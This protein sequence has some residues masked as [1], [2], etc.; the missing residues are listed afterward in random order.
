MA[1][2]R[3]NT[4][5]LAI[6]QLVVLVGG[7]GAVFFGLRR[8]S[9]LPLILAIFFICSI[10]ALLKFLKPAPVSKPNAARNETVVIPQLVPNTR[11]PGRTLSVSERLEALDWYQFERLLAAIYKE[12]GNDVERLGGAKP[13]GG[14]DFILRMGLITLPVQ[15]KH[16]KSWTVGVKEVREFLG[17][18]KDAGL[19]SGRLIALKDFSPDARALA[20]RNNVQLVDGKDLVKLMTEVNWETNPAIQAILSET[21]KICPQCDSRMILRTVEKGSRKGD[22]FWGCSQYPKCEGSLPH[23]PVA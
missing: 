10:V 8:A 11:A 6:I 1:R 18:I 23:V 4:V 19:E 21:I 16:W 9:P 15:S 17:A 13:D 14:I 22:R 3:G 7:S 12:K 2:S 5:E 20:Q